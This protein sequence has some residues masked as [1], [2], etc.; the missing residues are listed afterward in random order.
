MLLLSD[1]SADDERVRMQWA[2]ATVIPSERWVKLKARVIGRLLPP[3]LGKRDIEV[4]VDTEPFERGILYK[5]YL[6]EYSFKRG[7]RR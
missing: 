6:V 1:V 2:V 7:S 4:N 3:Q 5:E